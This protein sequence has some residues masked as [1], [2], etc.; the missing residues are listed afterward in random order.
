MRDLQRIRYVT[1]NFERLKGLRYVPFVLALVLWGFVTWLWFE[2]PSGFFDVQL[3][4]NGVFLL[5]FLVPWLFVR[6]IERYYEH[7]FGL[8]RQRR[9][10]PSGRG[11]LLLA[12]ALVVAIVVGL[13][14][15]RD[16]LGQPVLGIVSGLFAATLILYNWWP[17]RSKFTIHWPILAALAIVV[18]SLPLADI[19]IGEMFSLL[20]APLGVVFL[21][22]F[23]L[24]HLLLV[25]T[26]K[27]VPED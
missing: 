20:M 27:V 22:G 13:P 2:E 8:V 25:R 9:W 6:P 16:D 3:L 21:V 12:A 14:A 7:H 18:C 4:R 17:L 11:T 1:K 24:D 19:F 15:L 23:V 26:L 10:K 5:V